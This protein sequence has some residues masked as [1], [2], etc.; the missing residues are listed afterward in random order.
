VRSFALYCGTNLAARLCADLRGWIERQPGVH[1]LT[2]PLPG[3]NPYAR[4]GATSD[5]DQRYYWYEHDAAIVKLRACMEDIA[6]RVKPTVGAT[7][8]IATS[9]SGVFLA[10]SYRMLHEAHAPIPERITGSSD[11]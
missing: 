8:E 2:F 5:I 9:A 7:I 10:L 6:R 4:A 3:R 1:P 11:C